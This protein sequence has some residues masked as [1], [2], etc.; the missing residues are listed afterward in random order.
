MFLSET[1]ELRCRSFAHLVTICDVRHKPS[2]PSLILL[3]LCVYIST[4]EILCF[5]CLNSDYY[6]T[7]AI[8]NPNK[9]I[10]ENEEVY[11]L[12]SQ[13]FSITNCYLSIVTFAG[14]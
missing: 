10:T 7:I 4:L 14:W 6:C 3:E 11:N 9:R 13:L 5:E 8:D 12:Q 1:V 2:E